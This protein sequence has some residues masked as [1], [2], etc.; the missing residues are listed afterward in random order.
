[1]T[2]VKYKKELYG[3][4][5]LNMGF[6][7][8]EYGH[9]EL[10]GQLKEELFELSDYTNIHWKVSSSYQL[11]LAEEL[12]NSPSSSKEVT[13]SH[14]KIYEQMG[15]EDHYENMIEYRKRLIEKHKKT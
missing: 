6:Y 1:M 3:S 14:I 4:F 8:L 13:L 7:C 10:I 12:S 11:S 5:L 2:S 15:E 9:F